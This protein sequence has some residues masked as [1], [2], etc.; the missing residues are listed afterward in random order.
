MGCNN[1]KE[2]QKHK[3]QNKPVIP[4]RTQSFVPVRTRSRLSK[5]FKPE[6][7]VKS[8]CSNHS[9]N[10]LTDDSDFLESDETIV[11]K[12]SPSKGSSS[13]DEAKTP[14]E[15]STSPFIRPKNPEL[16]NLALRTKLSDA[17][18]FAAK[19]Y[20]NSSQISTYI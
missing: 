3:F 4:E 14:I 8:A 9:Q 11:F 20:S 5:M 18:I 12:G 1:T 6:R 15:P 13:R 10:G 19:N 2:K 7:K 16:P 17:R